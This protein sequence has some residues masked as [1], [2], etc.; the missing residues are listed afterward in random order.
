MNKKQ[1][2]IFTYQKPLLNTAPVKKNDCGCNCDCESTPGYSLE[3][4]IDFL[5]QKYPD[6]YEFIRI[7][8]QKEEN[9]VIISKLNKIF[10]ESGEKLNI[11]R[12]NLE[13]ILSQV[14]PLIVADGKIISAKT[15]PGEK[16][17]LKALSS[18]ERIP[19]KSTCC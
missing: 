7:D 12:T 9:E 13:F 2:E 11:K 10:S 6:R 19:V 16:E 15:I 5:N 1:I 14:T 4:L 8:S 17:L 18:G 3:N